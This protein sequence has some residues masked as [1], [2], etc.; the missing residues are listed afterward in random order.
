MEIIEINEP[1]RLNSFVAKQTNS[2]FLQSWH[3]SK[4]K[5]AQTRKVLRAGVEENGQLV[6]SAMALVICLPLSRSYV[7]CPRGPIVEQSLTDQK[8]EEVWGN[9]LFEIKSWAKQQEA[10][11]LRVEP[12]FRIDLQKY[13]LTPTKTI[14]PKDTLLLDL[15]KDED[16]LLS[17]MKQ[18][19]RY[20]IRL[21]EK[22]GVAVEEDCS[23]EAIDQ[24]CNLLS[25]TTERNQFR[26]HP[27]PYYRKMLDNL[28]DCGVVK[29]FLAKHQDKVVAA[30]L[31]SWFGDT[32]TYM[33]GASDYQSRNLMAPYLLQW[34]VIKWAQAAGYHYYDFW[35]IADNQDPQHPWAG[36]TR[37]KTGFG[38]FSEHYLGTWEFSISPLWHTVY[39]I[40]KRIK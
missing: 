29:L 12:T 8:K 16:R 33:H 25:Q 4:F 21:A 24:F 5:E 35:G 17:E 2:Q 3:W 30:N 36:I 19:T 15:S 27:L 22:K 9:L 28:S 13:H 6:G 32:V 40:V 1:S 26:P 37:F 20:N 18:K 31:T 39:N 38:G 10:M 23:Q 34:Q 7:Y 11:F 14:Q